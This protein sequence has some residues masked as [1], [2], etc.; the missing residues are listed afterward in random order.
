MR[1]TAKHIIL[2]SLGSLLCSACSSA[3]IA[4]HYNGDKTRDGKMLG[5]LYLSDPTE[6]DAS[7]IRVYRER[8][9]YAMR[10][11]LDNNE[12]SERKGDLIFSRNKE[13]SWFAGVNWKFNF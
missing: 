8:K 6:E 11:N 1:Q 10:A 3:N 13:Y 4:P 7:K 9:G 2:L 5:T 12:Q